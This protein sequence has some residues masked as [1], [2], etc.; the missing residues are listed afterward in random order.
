MSIFKKKDKEKKVKKGKEEE[1]ERKVEVDENKAS[2]KMSFVKNKKKEKKEEA[3]KKGKTTDAKKKEEKSA[4][5]ARIAYRTLISPH[6]TEKANNLSE[7]RKYIFR[8]FKNANKVMIKKSV[9][10]VYN[11]PVEKVMIINVRPKKR[12]LGRVEGKKPG[13]KKAI[14]KLKEGHSIEATP[15]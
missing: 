14:V 8:V 11:T 1:K 7:E 3:E 9:E 6:I 15:K 2:K 4:K 10:E 5:S 12:R 13:Y